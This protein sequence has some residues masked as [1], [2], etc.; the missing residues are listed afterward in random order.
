MFS[1]Q[2]SSLQLNLQASFPKQHDSIM[3][4]TPLTDD[5]TRFFATVKKSGIPLDD[6]TYSYAGENFTS[7]KGETVLTIDS[8]SS[9]P[10][11][12]MSYFF[13]ILQGT[14]EDGTTIGLLM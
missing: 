10:N 13:M 2:S 1:L 4:L 6:F 8:A 3:W 14:L 12:G 9:K 7:K 11:Y 5:K